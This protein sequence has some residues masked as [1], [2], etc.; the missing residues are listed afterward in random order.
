MTTADDKDITVEDVLNPD[1]FDVDEVKALCEKYIAPCVHYYYENPVLISK[2]NGATLYD[3]DGKE[4]IDLFAGVCTILSGHCNPK[5]T[6][7][8]KRQLDLLMHTTTLYPTVPMVAYAKKLASIAPGPLNKCF[9]VN[10]G[11]EANEAALHLIK[12]YKG[13]HFVM[14]LNGSF[15]GRTLM[16]MSLTN[17]GAWRQNLPYATGVLGAPHANCYRCAFGQEYPGCDYE[18]ARYAEKIIRCQTPNQI[19]GMIVEPIQGNGGVITPPP[20][21]FKILYEITKK[22]DGVFI[23]DEVQTGFGRTGKTWGIEHWNVT[24]DIITMAKGMA[25]GFPIGGFIARDEIA[26]ILNPKDLFST[27]GGNPLAMVAGLANIEVFMEED[28]PARAARLGAV[29]KKG[30]NELMESHSIIGDVRGKG[31]ML[32]FELVKSKDDKTPLTE[33]TPRFME[34]AKDMGLFIGAGGLE[35]NVVRIKPPLVMTPEQIDRSL[36][37][38]DSALKKLDS[39]L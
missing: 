21:Y 37:I 28:F 36:E 23:S 24:P 2:G 38:L 18:C 6:N 22:Y 3:S 35:G 11:S 1:S 12:M 7:A 39:T 17:Q 26:D 33:E 29:Y 31:L 30:L 13:S 16:A 14:S 5:I 19:A 20:E 34:I 27:Y 25:S 8:L 10:S 15:H 9:F 32:G 4:Y